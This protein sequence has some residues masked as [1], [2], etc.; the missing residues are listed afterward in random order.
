M[1]IPLEVLLLL[2]IVLGILGIPPILRGDAFDY[3]LIP[4]RQVLYLCCTTVQQRSH[5]HKGFHLGNTGFIS[6]FLAM[7]TV[8]ATSKKTM[9]KSRQ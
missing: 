5:K 2:R 8:S 4:V 1:A 9:H 3:V 6:L 7:C